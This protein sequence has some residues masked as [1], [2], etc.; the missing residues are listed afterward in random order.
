MPVVHLLDL[1][2][3][4]LFLI[5]K[6]TLL[7]LEVAVHFFEQFL[8]FMVH[9]RDHG[10]ESFK[11][12]VAL[13]LKVAEPLMVGLFLFGLNAG[14]LI[15]VGCVIVKHL[16]PGLIEIITGD[17]DLF[18]EVGKLHLVNCLFVF[19][20]SIEFCNL[21]L[22]FLALHLS[23]ELLV[24]FLLFDRRVEGRDIRLDLV[25]LHLGSEELGA[26]VDLWQI[27]DLPLRVSVS[28]GEYAQGPVL[29]SAEQSLVIV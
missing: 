5:L 9:F 21:A 28:K 15:E 24:C 20:L 16:L 27:K 14:L 26:R 17:L 2:G 7:H 1:V 11:L 18:F 25:T 22:V 19:L 12:L 13:S 29:R 10:L 3:E 8:V 23:L 4:L 6:F